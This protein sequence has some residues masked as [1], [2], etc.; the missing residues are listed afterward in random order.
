[1]HVTV[2]YLHLDITCLFEFN[3]VYIP[4]CLQYGNTRPQCYA[5]GRSKIFF[6]HDELLLCLVHY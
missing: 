5:T 6:P 4:C 2:I 1:M 3:L